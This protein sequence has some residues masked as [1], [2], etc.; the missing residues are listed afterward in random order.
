M[1]SYKQTPTHFKTE[2]Y[3]HIHPHF[4]K[5]EKTTTV[6]DMHKLLSHNIKEYSQNK[7]TLKYMAIY[8]QELQHNS[9][10]FI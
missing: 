5:Q 4:T 1:L 10:H 2:I 8:S 3:T 7:V 9:L 6:Q